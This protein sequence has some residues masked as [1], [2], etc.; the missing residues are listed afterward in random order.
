MNLAIFDLDGTLTDTNVVDSVCF[1][2]AWKETHGECSERDWSSFADVSDRGIAKALCERYLPPEE[3][4]TGYE[5]FKSAFLTRLASAIDRPESCRAIPGARE[6]LAVLPSRG[7]HAVVATGAW[8]ASAEIKLQAAGFPRDVPLT[9]SDDLAARC[10]IVRAAI[11]LASQ[12]HG[13][14]FERLVLLGDAPWDVA[15]AAEL[16]LPFVG[17]AAGPARDRLITA[18]VETILGDYSDVDA[19]EGFLRTAPVPDRAV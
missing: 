11:R 16:R 2:Q 1:L 14:A 13:G 7:W 19:V 17:R 12:I 5:R 10:D 9:A 8:K 18:G 15:A 4:E 3:R 6:L